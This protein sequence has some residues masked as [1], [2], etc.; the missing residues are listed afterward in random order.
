VLLFEAVLPLY[1]RFLFLVDA[2]LFESSVM[3]GV[4]KPVNS[5]ATGPC[6]SDR[7]W[8]WLLE[9]PMKM[10]GDDASQQNL[11]TVS[12]KRSSS[13]LSQLVRYQGSG[14]NIKTN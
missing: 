10:P 4:G 5:C 3:I 9:G 1:L 7:G 11:S 2:M 13:F 6:F 12:E 14:I 8:K